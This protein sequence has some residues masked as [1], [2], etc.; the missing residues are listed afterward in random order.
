MIYTNKALE[1]HLGIKLRANCNW[2]QKDIIVRQDC[3]PSLLDFSFSC[4]YCLQS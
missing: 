2:T 4:L 3:I 1:T